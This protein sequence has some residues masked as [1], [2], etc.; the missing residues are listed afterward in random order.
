MKDA[1]DAYN[2][3]LLQTVIAIEEMEDSVED[4]KRA[5]REAI[6]TIKDL[7]K[8]AIE[9]REDLYERMLQGTIDVENE[10]LD[11]IKA[12]YEKERDLAI[13]NSELKKDALQNEIDL[14]DEQLEARRRLADEEDRSAELA[15]L[16]A[17]LARIAADPTRA[18]ERLELQKQIKDLRDEIAWDEAEK[19]AESQKK[20]LQDQIDNIDEYIDYVNDYYDDMMENPQ[21]LIEEMKGVMKLADSEILNWLMANSEDYRASTAATMESMVNDWTG[22]LEDMR[23]NTKSYW[24]E[25]ESIISGGD[26]AIIAFLKENTQ[27]YKEAGKEQAE[28]FVGEWVKQLELWRAAIKDVQTSAADLNGN[29]TA[30]QILTGTVTKTAQYSY[31]N[32]SGK[33]VTVSATGTG[34]TVDEATKNAQAEAFSQ[35]RLAAIQQWSQKSGSTARKVTGGLA[36]ATMSSLGSHLKYVGA[37]KTGGM[38][39]ETGYAL[40]HK[41]ESVLTEAQTK[42][43]LML[44]DAISKPQMINVPNLRGMLGGSDTGQLEQL[45]VDGDININ[46]NDLSSD[47]DYEQ[48]GERAMDAILRSA[49]KR[50]A[51]VRLG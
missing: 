51:P 29:L 15:T 14:I 42:I 32:R 47:S 16:E 13:E 26:E 24:D 46:V 23:G 30:Q 50:T 45:Y 19:E 27:S 6:S 21:A 36:S 39:P 22:M 35:A 11:A 18:K 28:G 7:V 48:M 20:A 9:D 17:N 49:R 43:L 12:R 3:E 8:Q 38:I 44:R 25:V 34:K 37:Y 33:W 40:V 5:V 31:K 4:Q 10:I 1:I 41:N 2:K